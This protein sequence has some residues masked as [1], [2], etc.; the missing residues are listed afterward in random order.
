MILLIK[1]TLP[2]NITLPFT[3]LSYLRRK[4]L[5]GSVPDTFKPLSYLGYY[6]QSSE[7]TLSI[8]QVAN[9]QFAG[10]FK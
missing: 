5:V 6:L 7:N 3:A 2:D 8:Q 9:T 10:H 1:V 4:T